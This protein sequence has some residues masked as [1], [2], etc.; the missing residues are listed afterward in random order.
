M[1]DTASTALDDDH[2]GDWL[3]AQAKCS[4]QQHIGVSCTPDRLYTHYRVSTDLKCFG[5]DPDK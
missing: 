4:L 5:G 1:V 2:G 3:I